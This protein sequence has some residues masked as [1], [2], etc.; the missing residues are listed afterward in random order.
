[1][2]T[3][4]ETSQGSP[5]HDMIARWA[6]P[7]TVD[8][9]G[10]RPARGADMIMPT[11]IDITQDGLIGDRS[12]AGKRAVTLVQAEHL[13]VIAACLGRTTV[14]PQEL[15]RNLSI[16]GLNLAGLKGREVQV[17]TAVLRLTTICAP[18][19]QMERHFGHGGYAAVRGHGGWCAEVVTPGAVR[20]GDTV[21][22]L[23]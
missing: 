4:A 19:S 17:G 14:A 15:R 16:R 13:P 10:L 3:A 21:R 9:I 18:C 7:G 12:R 8:W 20:I 23:D 5:L 11:S 2:S 6:Q 1:M 22:P